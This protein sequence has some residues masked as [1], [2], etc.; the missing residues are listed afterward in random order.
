M[1]RAFETFTQGEHATNRSTVF[2]GL[3]LGLAITRELLQ[4]HSGRISVSSAGRNRGA[5]FT[6]ELPVESKTEH[7]KT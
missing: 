1:E 3:G 4:M 7:T 6:I 5:I 2:G